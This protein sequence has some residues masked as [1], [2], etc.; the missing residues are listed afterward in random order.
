M[1]QKK[2]KNS[3]P[4]QLSGHS[5][6]N[7]EEAGSEVLEGSRFCI[8]AVSFEEVKSFEDFHIVVKGLC[9][10]RELPND[11]RMRF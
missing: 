4:A 3:A 5:R 6:N 11:V 10:D 8:Q 1:I 7:S 2:Q 9:I